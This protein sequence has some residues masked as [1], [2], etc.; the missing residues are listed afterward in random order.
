MFSYQYIA[1]V[2]EAKKK[3]KKRGGG[4]G[5]EKKKRKKKREN[6]ARARAATHTVNGVSMSDASDYPTATIGFQLNAPVPFIQ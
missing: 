1:D 3:K 6:T 2:S 4:G 5:E